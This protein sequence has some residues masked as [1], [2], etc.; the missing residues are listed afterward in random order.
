MMKEQEVKVLR[1]CIDYDGGRVS[2]FFYSLLLSQW[3]HPWLLPKEET[4]PPMARVL[5]GESC[6][7]TRL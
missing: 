1:C 7:D 3:T 6:G 2:V 4:G 5:L